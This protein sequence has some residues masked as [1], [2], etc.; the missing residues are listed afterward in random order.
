M[1]KE[2]EDEAVVDIET[3]VMVEVEAAVVN[4]KKTKIERRE[5]NII[6]VVED[7]IVKEETVHTDLMQIVTIAVSMDTTQN[8]VD[9]RGR[10]KKTRTSRQKRQKTMVFS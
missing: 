1:I 2:E 6:G 4:K 3:M 8:I 10:Y 5:V 7:I 9:P